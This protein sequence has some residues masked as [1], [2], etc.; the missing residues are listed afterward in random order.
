M[1]NNII[2]FFKKNTPVI[3]SIGS[4]IGL[5]LTTVSAIRS[6]PKALKLL[7][8]AVTEK[9]EVL[10]MWEEVKIVGPTY[11]PTTLLGLGTMGC[12]AGAGIMNYKAQSSLIS[13]YTMLNSSYE[14]YKE[15]VGEEKNLEIQTKMASE[16]AITAANIDDLPIALGD[17]LL[18][19]DDNSGRYFNRSME[20]VLAA[21]Y[22]LNK[23][24]VCRGYASLN[25]FYKLLL[26]EDVYYGDQIG[27]SVH[28]GGYL[29]IDF[30]HKFVNINDDLECY[31]L[32]T[33]YRPE[34]TYLDC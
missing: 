12:I 30:N 23:L 25:D 9:G 13:A 33:P 21:E 11:I 29:W 14:R 31:I 27:W 17:E 8:D 3:L 28:D 19:Y 15:L 4:G 1:K 7:N 26:I 18:F 16:A 5:V 34:A 6:T 32:T 20:E 10:S 22:D 2:R 24:F